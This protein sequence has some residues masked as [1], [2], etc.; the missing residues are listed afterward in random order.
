MSTRGGRGDLAEEL[1][2]LFIPVRLF[3]SVLWKKSQ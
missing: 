1:I 3:T 2:V